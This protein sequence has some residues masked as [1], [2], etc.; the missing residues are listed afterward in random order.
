MAEMAAPLEGSPDWASYQEKI[1]YSLQLSK[2]LEKIHESLSWLSKYRYRLPRRREYHVWSSIE[3]DTIKILKR[4]TVLAE[5]QKVNIY[6]MV[7]TIPIL[8]HNPDYRT[9]RRYILQAVSVAEEVMN[10]LGLLLTGI[11]GDT[12]WDEDFYLNEILEGDDTFQKVE[13]VE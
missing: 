12:N 8:P 6:G 1:F 4:L 2:Q 11:R 9:W 3:D 13:G 7:K 5:R 10:L